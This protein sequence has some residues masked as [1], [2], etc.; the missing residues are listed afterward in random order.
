MVKAEFEYKAALRQLRL[1]EKHSRRR[2]RRQEAAARRQEAAAR[3]QEASSTTRATCLTVRRRAVLDPKILDAALLV[4]SMDMRVCELLENYNLLHGYFELLPFS[5]Y[6]CPGM[7]IRMTQHTSFVS[8]LV[9]LVFH[10]TT[11]WLSSL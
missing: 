9:L 6:C 7:L 4:N 10:R 11:L 8:S 5:F 2:L 1:A 3:W